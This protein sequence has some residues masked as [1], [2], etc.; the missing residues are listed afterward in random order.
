MVERQLKK[1]RRRTKIIDDLKE[2]MQLQH[3]YDD[4]DDCTK[5][6]NIIGLWFEMASSIV[7]AMVFVLEEPFLLKVVCSW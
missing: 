5:V 2:G 7:M 6:N 1:G 4:E 3:T